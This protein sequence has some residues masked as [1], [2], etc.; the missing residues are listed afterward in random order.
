MEAIKDVHIPSLHTFFLTWPVIR[1]EH[2]SQ[3]LYS[4]ASTL[5]AVD[6]RDP[7]FYRSS[8]SDVLDLIR[9]LK[10]CTEL[11][12]LYFFGGTIF[13]GTVVFEGL[14]FVWCEHDEDDDDWMLVHCC[15][16]LCFDDYEEVQCGLAQAIEGLRILPS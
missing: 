3:F 14:N 15:E 2:L 1:A 10:A 4:H 11:E 16:G 12:F 6:L 8:E 5:L 9:T 7:H 13:H